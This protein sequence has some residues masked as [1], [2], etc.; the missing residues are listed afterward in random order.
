M[1]ACGGVLAAPG[2]GGVSADG[3]PDP[4][5]FASRWMASVFA[6]D[7]TSVP[8]RSTAFVHPAIPETGSCNN[9]YQGV[10]L[11][12]GDGVVFVG[13]FPWC[14]EFDGS[15]CWDAAPFSLGTLFANNG[16][17]DRVRYPDM[18]HWTGEALPSPTTCPALNV[19]HLCGLSCGDC[20]ADYSCYGRSPLHPYS[21][22]V[23]PVND[24]CSRKAGTPCADPS[25]K[26][27]TF[28]VEDVDQSTADFRSLCFPVDQCLDL[29]QNLPG[30][31]FCE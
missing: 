30:G 12:G 4:A 10:C 3:E 9:P 19:A 5:P 2:D 7:Q 8:C 28:K 25:N 6:M 13:E 18:S 26:C 21:V 16:A 23:P 24:S 17:A 11:L 27:F 15:P 29:T 31:A 14:H 20:P 1:G 22:C